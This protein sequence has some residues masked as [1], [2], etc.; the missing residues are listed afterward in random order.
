MIELFDMGKYDFYVWSSIGIFI[1][2]LL[3]DII[4]TRSQNKT[5]KR[6]IKSQFQRTQAQRNQVQ[7]NQAQ[8]KES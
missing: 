4:S 5:V 2:A 7:P 6:N 3:F 8:R 1:M